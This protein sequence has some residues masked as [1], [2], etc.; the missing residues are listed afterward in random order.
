MSP[1]CGDTSLCARGE[2]PLRP[3]PDLD[4]TALKTIHVVIYYPNDFKDALCLSEVS[5]GEKS[6]QP[7]NFPT[8]VLF[9]GKETQVS[10]FGPCLEDNHQGIATAASFQPT[11]SSSLASAS[12]KPDEMLIIDIPRQV[13]EQEDERSHVP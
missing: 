2:R 6:G 5:Q 10:T 7:P 11:S 13:N 1:R 3:A 9:W 12:N 8:N 4:P